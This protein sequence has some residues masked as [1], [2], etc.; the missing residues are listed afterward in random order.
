MDEGPSIARA[1][2]RARRH[3]E[4]TQEELARALGVPLRT[5]Q[6]W[7]AGGP[8][9]PPMRMLDALCAALRVPCEYWRRAP[10]EDVDRLLVE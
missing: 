3:R 8:G 9:E 1:L 4:L 5:L 7:E 6:N 10:Y 2:R